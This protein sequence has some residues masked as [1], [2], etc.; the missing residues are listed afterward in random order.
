[1]IDTYVPDVEERFNVL[2]NLAYSFP[3]GVLLLVV[4]FTDRGTSYRELKYM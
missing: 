2:L 1:M 4:V 3:C